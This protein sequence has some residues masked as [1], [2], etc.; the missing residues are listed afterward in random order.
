MTDARVGKKIWVI[1]NL[2]G[3]HQCSVVAD[4]EI[5]AMEKACRLLVK[6][7]DKLVVLDT[8]RRQP[9]CCGKK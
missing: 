2:Q 1:R 6:T 8:G 3:E 4:T 9:K 5:E 7:A